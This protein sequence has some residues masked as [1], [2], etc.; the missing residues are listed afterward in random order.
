MIA[1]FQ[2]KLGLLVKL[3]VLITFFCANAL[4]AKPAEIQPLASQSL[5]TD[6]IQFNFQQQPVFIA[7]GE[8]GHILRAEQGKTEQLDW[9]QVANPKS[10]ML[11]KVFSLQSNTSLVWAV[12]H[13]GL[14]LHSKDAGL[15]WH[16][17]HFAPELDK[18]LMDIFFFNEQHG[19]AV[20]AYGL[21]LMTHDGGAS[22]QSQQHESLLT[23]DD[24]EYLAE[25]RLE[26]EEDYLDELSAILPHM[27][28]LAFD[29]NSLWLAGERGLVATS[30]DK[31][32]SWQRQDIEYDGSMFTIKADTENAHSIVVAGLRGN[33]FRTKNAG[34][35]WYASHLPEPS[36]INAIKILE[37]GILLFTHSQQVWYWHRQ[38]KRL[39]A[40]FKTQS[41]TQLGAI[42]YQDKLITIG[43]QGFEAFVFNEKNFEQAHRFIP[44]SVP[45]SSMQNQLTK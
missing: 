27:N 41:K 6:I 24:R 34:R 17:Q 26:S 37:Q 9:Q 39:T 43:D 8:R 38:S 36:N 35:I 31:G 4:F 18:P 13:N 22:W 30:K 28:Q 12:G 3:T 23:R 1:A 45:V 33:F 10:D 21:Y 14:I 44:S 32:Q 42:K 7:V 11:T 5:L 29:G 25:V 15:N 19:V 2:F 20:G 16:V 40:A